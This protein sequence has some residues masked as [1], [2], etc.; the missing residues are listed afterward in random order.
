[1]IKNINYK[2]NKNINKII[3]EEQIK[4]ILVAISGGQ[5]S[6]CLIQLIENFN[7][8]KM[9]S[10]ILIEYIYID[11]QWKTSCKNQVHYI[12]NY[13]Q[14]LRK[15]IAIYQIQ[16]KCHNEAEARIARYKAIISHAKNNSYN[17][18]IT[19]HSKTDKNETFLY[20]AIRGSSV[21]GLNNLIARKK[22]NDNIYLIRPLLIFNRQN[23]E[24]LCRN[25]SLP[26]WSDTTNYYY[27]IYRNKIRY[28]IV[29]YC[30][31]YL[32]YNYNFYC[33]LF[34]RKTH[35]ENE[36]IKQIAI[37]LYIKSRHIKYIALNKILIEKQHQAIQCRI[38]QLFFQ[39]NFNKT[40]NKFLIIKL[41]QLISLR[42]IN[43][44]I[45]WN[46]I[47]INITNKWIY[48]L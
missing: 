36:Y 43:K 24:W 19:G 7:K 48:I 2:F 41:T 16:K 34:F 5:D 1:M 27:E 10:K 42:N 38:L 8:T 22:I 46:K 32:K 26:I 13:I 18:I 47:E 35:Q 6:L 37:K 39:H 12:I 40:P 23:I 3:Q 21:E 45:H 15:T 20:Q 25:S 11:H 31:K 28:E 17:A 33:N 30:Q 44:K 29:P 9:S 14:S 4:S